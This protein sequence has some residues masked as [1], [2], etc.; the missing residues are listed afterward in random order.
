MEDEFDPTIC[1]EMAVDHGVLSVL[2]MF[3]DAALALPVVPIAIN[4][5]QHPLP[6]ARRLFRLGAAVR[7]A[8][9]SVSAG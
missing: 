7:R 2:P 5:I 4:V 8:I 6:T 9:E 3:G 1:Q